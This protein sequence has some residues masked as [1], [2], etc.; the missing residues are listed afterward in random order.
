VSLIPG[1][2]ERRIATR[3][4]EIALASGGSGPPLLLL[5][6]YPE[7][8]AC[9]HEVAPRLA[10]SFTVIC[11]DLRGYGASRFTGAE[12]PDH[13]A[14]AKRAMA[15]DQV[16]VMAALGFP[17]FAVAGHDRGG[18]VAYRLALDHPDCVTRL[19]VLDI[20]PTLETFER[21][22]KTGALAAYHWL[23][24]AQNFDLPERLI[25][26][27]SDFYL[28]WTIASWLGPGAALAPAAMAE[29]RRA[30]RDPA[31]IHA[32]CEDYR[33][34]AAIDCDIDR[35]DRDAGRR[36]RCPVLALWGERR[37]FSAAAAAGPLETWRRW[38][39]AVEGTALACGHF[40]PEE[41]P[42]PVAD[43]LQRFFSP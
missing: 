25:A 22:T 38:A 35:A 40:L 36:I 28:D 5:H 26:A 29:Y 20:V 24:L 31:V 16:A 33:A 30:F 1:F 13:A 8:H 4:A 17:R 41:A 23:F 39:D 42:G 32:A 2:T 27:Q 9:W 37:S 14:F 11:P 7:T 12:T 6:G 19:A 21:M 43:A 3:A 10:R 15:E 18:R 34:G